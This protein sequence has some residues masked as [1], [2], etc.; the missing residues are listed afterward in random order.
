MR[1]Y[2]FWA[3][4]N[5]EGDV[6]THNTTRVYR[7]VNDTIGGMI[8]GLYG[9]SVSSYNSLHHTLKL[10]ARGSVAGARLGH[11]VHDSIAGGA[12][13]KAHEMS[14]A[15]SS[16]SSSLMLVFVLSGALLAAA[17][18][19]TL[20]SS[21]VV[22]YC[23]A[24]ALLE[25]TLSLVS[26]VSASTLGA[27][28]SLQHLSSRVYKEE[29]S[30]I[31]S[32][33]A[34]SLSAEQGASDEHAG[35]I[36]TT[37]KDSMFGKKAARFSKK[38]SVP[39][40]VL[41]AVVR[42]ILPIL[43][44]IL[45]VPFVPLGMAAYTFI[46]GYDLYQERKEQR[47]RGRDADKRALLDADA[48]ELGSDGH[49]ERI[50]G[51]DTHNFEERIMSLRTSSNLNS[52]KSQTNDAYI[53]SSTSSSSDA[54][55]EAKES[56]TSRFSS[57][58]NLIARMSKNDGTTGKKAVTSSSG[59]SVG[60]DK[61]E[62]AP[63]RATRAAR[64]PDSG[65]E[66]GTAAKA[67]PSRPPLPRSRSTT[68]SATSE[69]EEVY[70][71]RNKKA[72]EAESSGTPA[73]IGAREERSNTPA[74]TLAQEERVAAKKQ[75]AVVVEPD[76]SFKPSR[77]APAVPTAR[78]Q[79]AAS[80]DDTATKPARPSKP[81]APASSS[82]IEAAAATKRVDLS[83]AKK[84]SS[85]PSKTLFAEARDAI[86]SI[87]SRIRQFDAE[88]EAQQ[89]TTNSASKP[90]QRTSVAATTTKIE[91]SASVAQDTES[92]HVSSAAAA[93][94]RTGTKPA[95]PPRPPAP[96][97][98]KAHATYA[99]SIAAAKVEEGVDY[100]KVQRETTVHVG[101]TPD[102]RAEHSAPEQES[103]IQTERVSPKPIRA[104]AVS[105]S[106]NLAKPVPIV[107]SATH[108]DKPPVAPKPRGSVIASTSIVADAKRE[109]EMSTKREF[110]ASI[111]ASAAVDE[112]ASSVAQQTQ[113]AGMFA[114]LRAAVFGGKSA[115]AEPVVAK[116]SVLP[117]VRSASAPPTVNTTEQHPAHASGQNSIK[118]AS[119]EPSVSAPSQG[120]EAALSV[121]EARKKFSEAGATQQTAQRVA[122]RGKRPAPLPP[123]KGEAPHSQLTGQQAE[124][125]ASSPAT[126]RGR[127][128]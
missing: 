128:V 125:V 95:R 109:F 92:V 24:I 96:A 76:Q 83:A 11:A 53:S 37:P 85:S 119:S 17:T 62:L 22:L 45:T 118:Q 55:Y 106:A 18:V 23:T 25:C 69:L 10:A 42:M 52:K 124:V 103:A 1:T 98:K 101:K 79:R 30:G 117:T 20:Y 107:P 120:E 51:D 35:E 94:E 77:A 105:Q 16:V 113:K 115:E 38:T 84:R 27:L 67:K 46:A 13:A 89:G 116:Q 3:S 12:I 121:A 64:L 127:G 90:T 48:Q 41:A 87:G 50:I 123:V 72:A 19:T 44:A 15:G 126:D 7:L 99:N 74:M 2:K 14:R 81:P 88:T 29:I 104:G 86:S 82:I 34:N 9:S 21:V 61:D 60:S 68:S 114:R 57:I 112:N 8:A 91:R 54:S 80:P 26:Q 93:A 66:A 73:A 43:V 39:A 70:N 4:P 49:Y 59:E 47:A 56:T 40:A 36:T 75:Q 32:H 33:A 31:R 5:K 58:K 102:T 122:S 110:T 97:A 108:G 71:R 63:I 65:V 111:P 6:L 100:A 78:K 28:R